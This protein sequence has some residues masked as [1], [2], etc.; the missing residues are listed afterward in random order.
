MQN[1]CSTNVSTLFR[2][3]NPIGFEGLFISQW[4]EV[5][6]RCMT[7]LAV[8][9]DVDV[10]THGGLGVPTC[11][12]VLQIDA[13]GREGMPEALCHGVIPTVA[14]APH[15]GLQPVPRQ[16]LPIAVGALR[17]A[18]IGMHDEPRRGLALKLALDNAW[19]TTSARLGAAMDQPP[20][21]REYRASPTARS[22][23][24]APR[25]GRY[26]RRHRRYPELAPS[27]RGC[28]GAVPPSAPDR[29]RSAR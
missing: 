8:L 25:E 23:Q 17:T 14:R 24:P 15:P 3:K 10:C 20:T 21:A 5:I 28:G 27:T 6:M 2:T 11:A 29:R 9:A 19:F 4:G 22:R 26:D 7:A 13:C 12:Q 16:E 1:P 18:T